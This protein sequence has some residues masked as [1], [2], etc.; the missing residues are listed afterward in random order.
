MTAYAFLRTLIDSRDLGEDQ[1]CAAI[2][3]L[4]LVPAEDLVAARV[5]LDS[6]CQ[7]DDE[8]VRIYVEAAQARARLDVLT[9]RDL[10]RDDLAIADYTGTAALAYDE[11]IAR[12]LRGES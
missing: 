10:T 4:P 5:L 1:R 7:S 3:L 2:R 11:A 12:H 9:N 8:T 6:L